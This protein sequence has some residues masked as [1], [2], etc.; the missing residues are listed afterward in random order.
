MFVCPECG[1]S[2]ANA[3][4]CTEHGGALLSSDDALLGTTVGSYRVGRLIGRGGMGSVYLGVHPAIGSRVAIKVLTPESSAS[5]GLVERF[6]SEARA[7]CVIRNE[8][9]VNVL[10][11]KALPDGRPYIVM[12][13]L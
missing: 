11:L 1:F 10:D 2:Q 8:N 6:F 13:Y 9:I 3:G 7:V 5:P 12:E 4:F